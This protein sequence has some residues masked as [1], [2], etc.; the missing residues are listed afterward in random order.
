[1]NYLMIV[2]PGGDG[3][4]YD[5]CTDRE[6]TISIYLKGALNVF[7]ENYNRL[8]IVFLKP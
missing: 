1:M 4:V 3:K 7:Q 6:G 2:M 5:S 8:T